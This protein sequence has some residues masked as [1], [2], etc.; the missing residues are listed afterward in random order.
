MTLTPE[1]EKVLKEVAQNLI[2]ADRLGRLVQSSLLWLVALIGSAWAVF[3]FF[4]KG[5][6]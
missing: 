4:L 5:K 1:E 3:E 2:S 6:I